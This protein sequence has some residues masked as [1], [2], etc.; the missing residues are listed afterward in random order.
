MLILN[1]KENQ[2]IDLFLEDGQEIKITL[3]WAHAY[4]AKIGI[5]APK[6]IMILREE[7][8]E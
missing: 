1:R 3:A 4:Q 2:S 7:L 6:E 8:M 5:T